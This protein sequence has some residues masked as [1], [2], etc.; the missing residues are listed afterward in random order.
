MS[1]L[2]HTLRTIAIALALAGFLFAG[3]SWSSPVA[4]MAG[5]STQPGD[6]D[7]GSTAPT[8][9]LAGGSTKPGDIDVGSTAPTSLLAGGSTKP[10]D[11]DVG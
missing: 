10:G 5:G 4:S 1:N 2:K 8:T 3:T 11:I 6:V 7:V 9:F